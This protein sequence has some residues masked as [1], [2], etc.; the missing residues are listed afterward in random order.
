MAL[1]AARRAIA[2][3]LWPQSSRFF[4]SK[5]EVR[6]LSMAESRWGACCCRA[7]RLHCR[8]EVRVSSARQ[9]RGA[10]VEAGPQQ[11][12]CMRIARGCLHPHACA[13][14]RPAIPGQGHPFREHETAVENFYFNKEDERALLKLLSKVKQAS[15]PGSE[16][17]STVAA[18]AAEEARV[19]TILSKYNVAQAVRAAAA[20]IRHGGVLVPGALGR[21]AGTRQQGGASTGAPATGRTAPMHFCS[22][23][24][25]APWPGR[26]T[27]MPS[28]PGSTSTFKRPEA[29][30]QHP[31][32]FV[33]AMRG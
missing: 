30:L 19:R 8:V 32:P 10:G 18:S 28:S 26:R 25:T 5:V 7:A 24:P 3:T 29:L 31:P 17:A 9:M 33:G 12:S 21:P 13:A 2:T 20:D 23:A 27:S 14:L 22:C 6:I 16:T 11:A 4:A 15:P 1:S